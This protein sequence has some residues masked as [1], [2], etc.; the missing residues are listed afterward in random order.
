MRQRYSVRVDTAYWELGTALPNQ[1]E[2]EVIG[3]IPPKRGKLYFWGNPIEPSPLVLSSYI[4]ADPRPAWL[5][6]TSGK[7]RIQISNLDKGNTYC[8][9]TGPGPSPC[10]T[11]YSVSGK[12]ADTVQGR[13]ANGQT[14]TF[15]M[16]D[17]PSNV[18]VGAV[19][20]FVGVGGSFFVDE[21][22]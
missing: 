4:A 8:R 12:I 18:V 6:P 5:C 21:N 19:V 11:Q 2:T 22:G 7:Y 15:T 14:V 20:P 16:Q 17:P 10:Y 3:W 9:D 1:I 13:V